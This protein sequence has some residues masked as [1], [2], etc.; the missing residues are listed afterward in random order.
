MTN[1]P[2]KSQGYAEGDEDGA[3]SFPKNSSSRML[4]DVPHSCTVSRN[5]SAC[6]QSVFIGRSRRHVTR[7]DEFAT[8]MHPLHHRY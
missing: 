2:R 8:G 4:N 1:E 3:L 7:L 5:P 6:E